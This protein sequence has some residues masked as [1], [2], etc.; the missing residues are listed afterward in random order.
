ME[1]PKSRVF[2][3]YNFV[4]SVTPLLKFVQIDKSVTFARFVLIN[5]GRFAGIATGS[6]SVWPKAA[7]TKWWR[8]SDKR[9]AIVPCSSPLLPFLDWFRTSISL[10]APYKNNLVEISQ[11][12]LHPVPDYEWHGRSTV[13]RLHYSHE[14]QQ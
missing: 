8:L 1:D 12:D 4:A 7:S 13:K 11:I 5:F 2:S 14:Q 10:E 6:L 3:G 9:V